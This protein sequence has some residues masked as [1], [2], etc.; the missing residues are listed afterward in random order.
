M[1]TGVCEVGTRGGMGGQPGKR[2]SIGFVGLAC[3]ILV[4]RVVLGIW[5]LSGCRE[6]AGVWGLYSVCAWP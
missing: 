5:W 2:A 1:R 6:E 3:S 4:P